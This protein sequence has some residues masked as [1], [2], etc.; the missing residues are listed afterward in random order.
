MFTYLALSLE[1]AE[2]DF[3]CLFSCLLL[4]GFSGEDECDLLLADGFCFAG[5]SGEVE[6]ECREDC[7]FLLDDS[8]PWR[9][10][11]D[12][13]GEADLISSFLLLD[14]SGD[15]ERPRLFG[16]L[17]LRCSGRRSRENF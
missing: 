17:L 8:C 12:E 15:G 6:G 10:L 7:D 14:L 1:S 3:E 4:L 2:R 13:S 9:D 16:D 11:G 5:G